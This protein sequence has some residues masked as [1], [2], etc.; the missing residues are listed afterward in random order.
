MKDIQEKKVFS[1][2][3]WITVAVDLAVLFFSGQYLIAHADRPGT[4][5][6]LV[7]AVLLAILAFMTFGG[8][9]LIHPNES[10]VFMFLGKYVGSA[11]TAGFFWAHPLL[12]PK[13]G[14][15]PILNF[16]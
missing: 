4:T 9:F 16:H 15:P 10:K 6:G 3:G 7:I 1:V 12:L 13:K 8:F 11:R 5:A 14:A 2:N